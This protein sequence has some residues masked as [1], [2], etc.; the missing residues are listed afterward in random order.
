MLT[1][2]FSLFYFTGEFHRFLLTRTC[3]NS[4]IILEHTHMLDR[5]T[6][7]QYI[8]EIN[9]SVKSQNVLCN[10]SNRVCMSFIAYRLR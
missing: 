4:Q 5:R 3:K 6:F 2:L 1:S 7:K 8:I 10:F 9:L